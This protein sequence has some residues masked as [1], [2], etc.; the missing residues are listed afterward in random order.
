MMAATDGAPRWYG[1]TAGTSLP[2]CTRQGAK[3]LLQQPLFG[4]VLIR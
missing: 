1:R 2:D 4:T 3:G